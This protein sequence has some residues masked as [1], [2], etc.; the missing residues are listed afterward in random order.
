VACMPTSK[1]LS[2]ISLK[3]SLVKFYKCSGDISF[4]AKKLQISVLQIA[5]TIFNSRVLHSDDTTVTQMGHSL[6]NSLLFT[7]IKFLLKIDG[8]SIRINIV[9]YRDTVDRMSYTIATS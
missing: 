6:E 8:N 5:I 1:L 7:R 3:I 4:L 2:S 9:C